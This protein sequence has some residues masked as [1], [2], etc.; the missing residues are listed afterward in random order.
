MVFTRIICENILCMIKHRENVWI[1][2]QNLNSEFECKKKIKYKIQVQILSPKFK[3]Y[4]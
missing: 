4:I 3:F 1:E 2:V